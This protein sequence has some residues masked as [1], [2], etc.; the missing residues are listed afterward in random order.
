[1]SPEV[2]RVLDKLDHVK[3]T[4]GGWIARCPA[5]EDGR[6]SLKIDLGGDDRVLLHC[7]A[8][9]EAK[10]IVAA[11][12]LDLSDLF[13]PKKG[14]KRPRGK[15]V[16]RTEYRVRDERGV[17]VATHVRDVYESGEK[18]VRWRRPNGQWGLGG[19]PLEDL[20]LYGIDELDDAESVVITEGEK[21]R[22]ALRA[23]KITAVGT[24]TGSSSAP[25]PDALRPIVG[26]LAVLWG[27]RDGSGDAHMGRVAQTLKGVGQDPGLI[28]RVA[29][30]D[31][32][33]GGDAADWDGDRDELVDLIEGAEPWPFATNGAHDSDKPPT[34]AEVEEEPRRGTLLLADFASYLPER[35]YIYLPTGTIWDPAGVNRAF[36]PIGAGKDAIKQSD[37]IDDRC[38]VHDLT[39]VPGKPQ[40]IE[41]AFLSQGGWIEKDGARVYNGYRPPRPMDGIA[42]AATRWLDHVRKVYPDDA[43][44]IVDWL[45]HRVQRP[46]EKLNHALVLGGVQGIGKDTILE[47]V[48]QAVGP[49]NFGDVSPIELVGRFNAF[50]K[51]VVL[52]VSELRD[53][54]DRDR[55]G[56]YEHTKTLIA[57]PPDTVLIDEKNIRAYRVPNVVG[58]VFT[59]NHRTDGLFLPTDDRRHY[60]AWSELTPDD[61]LADYW[62]ELYR[63]FDDD[64]EGGS[65]T[66][67]VAA[68]LA[69]RDLSGF[70]PKAPPPKTSAFWDVVAAGRA[71][72][73]A[74]VADAI[75]RLG[76]PQAIATPDGPDGPDTL[77]I[78]DLAT[79][80]DWEFV[81]WLRDRKN[82]RQ[83]PH[84]MEA[85]GYVAARNPDAK[86][87][88]WVVDGRRQVV[89]ASRELSIRE[90]IEAAR[91][92]TARPR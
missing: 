62:A 52:R 61:F 75:A 30:S 28:R 89:Y 23:R 37:L 1:M 7:Y 27:D 65:G 64:G 72:E 26:R 70:D 82:A 18:A 44:R 59:T 10:A 14:E 2:R 83:I 88:L 87:G 34:A 77:T 86:D 33:P 20:P 92:R 53:L 40:I 35:T 31:A 13:P 90:R 6:P 73:D 54:G 55:F 24:V 21:A 56:F 48:R 12:G 46:G 3:A 69:A 47:P 41:G 9:C 43:E 11:I 16:E 39:W 66:A 45:A 76:E 49:W 5:H 42:G 36:P 4:A 58:V 78:D 84:R 38:P 19:F 29:W 68:Y 79:V 8:G 15:L 85:A 80:G 81:S 91:K 74:D 51:A 57:A 17:L 22:D 60:V 25:G 67:H 32:P 50:L 71:P 63:W